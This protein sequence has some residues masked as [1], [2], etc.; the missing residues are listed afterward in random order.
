MPWLEHLFLG[1]LMYRQD[2]LMLMVA[3]GFAWSC[4]R[5]EQNRVSAKRSYEKRAAIQAGVEQVSPNSVFLL[6]SCAV[7]MSPATQCVVVAQP[8]R[9][10]AEEA[11]AA[12]YTAD[13][14]AP[15]N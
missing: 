3:L 14:C 11:A 9:A 7:A 4:C 5:R 13:R 2:L 15:D 10:N 1:W 6:H 12:D 8:G